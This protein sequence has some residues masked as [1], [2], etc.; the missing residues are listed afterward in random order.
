M[1]GLVAVLA[2]ALADLAELPGNELFSLVGVLCEWI[3]G[4]V[5]WRI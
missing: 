5:A 3:C 4:V 1:T 2:D